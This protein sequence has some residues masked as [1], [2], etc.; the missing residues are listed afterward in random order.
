[1]SQHISL[2]LDMQNGKLTESRLG[3]FFNAVRLQEKQDEVE[4]WIEERYPEALE[5]LRK[6]GTKKLQVGTRNFRLNRELSA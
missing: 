6:I 1:V 3:N 4:K 5:R 2:V